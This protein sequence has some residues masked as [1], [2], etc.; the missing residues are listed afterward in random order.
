MEGPVSE[1]GVREGGARGGGGAEEALAGA[2]VKGSQ[3][4][5]DGRRTNP[6]EEEE[7]DDRRREY[8][9]AGIEGEAQQPHPAAAAR[10]RSPPRWASKL[11]TAPKLRTMCPFSPPS[12]ETADGRGL[13][14]HLPHAA[15][16]HVTFDRGAARGL[17]DLLSSVAVGRGGEKKRRP[18]V[19]DLNA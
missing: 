14:E 2:G 15:T 12:P 5:G 3:S 8:R 11:P 13:P 7:E 17:A 4:R 9:G 16:D 19:L 10:P 18:S 6:G 1:G